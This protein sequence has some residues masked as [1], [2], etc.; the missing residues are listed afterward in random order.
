ML[1]TQA[2]AAVVFLVDASVSV[3]VGLVLVVVVTEWVHIL[4]LLGCQ[5]VAEERTDVAAG[6]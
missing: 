1:V 3:A 6:L 2:L 5:N 4:H